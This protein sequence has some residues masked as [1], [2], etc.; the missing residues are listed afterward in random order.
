MWHFKE[1]KMAYPLC[2]KLAQINT[3]L[4]WR[5]ECVYL[6][7]PYKEDQALVTCFYWIHIRSELPERKTCRFSL[8]YSDAKYSAFQ[9]GTSCDF[10]VVCNPRWCEDEWSEDYLST[11]ILTAQKTGFMPALAL[12]LHLLSEVDGFLAAATFVSSSERHSA[13]IHF[14][15]TV[16]ITSHLW[17]T[18]QCYSADG[19][20]LHHLR[21]DAII[22]IKG[23]VPA[24]CNALLFLSLFLF[25]S[26]YLKDCSFLIVK[27]KVPAGVAH[28]APNQL[29]QIRWHHNTLYTDTAS[30]SVLWWRLVYCYLAQKGSNL[31]AWLWINRKFPAFHFVIAHVKSRDLRQPNKLQENKTST[32]W[33]KFQYRLQ[34]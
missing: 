27:Y 30:M 9:P 31:P 4:C 10:R 12:T 20:P 13:S 21:L 5:G 33:G 24:R 28:M 26:G 18:H 34:A 15:S 17:S 8:S 14:S 11:F 1:V 23:E 7:L 19:G 2:A 25:Q 32:V 16:Y 3:C 29:I 6:P 22:P